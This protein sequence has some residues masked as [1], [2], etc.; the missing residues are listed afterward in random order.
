MVSFNSAKYSLGDTLRVET[1]KD[2]YEGTFLPSED[3]TLITLKLESGY[4]VGVKIKNIKKTDIVEKAKPKKVAPN[5]AVKQDTSLPKITILHTGG[6]IAS[7]VDYSTGGVTA[8]FSPEELL[9]LFPELLDVAQIDSKLVKQMMSENMRFDHYNLLTKAVQAEVKKGVDGIIITHGTDT[10]HYSAASLAFSLVN[11]PIPVIIVGAQRSSDRGSSDAA[12]NLIAAATF[13][14]E[15]D[16]SEVAVCMHQSMNDDACY[17]LPATKVRKMHTSRRD[18][19][20]SINTRPFAKVD[21]KSGVIE[22]INKAYVKRGDKKDLEVKLFKPE[23]KVGL[24]KSHTHMYEEEFLA[25]KDFDGLVIEGTALGQ[26][27]NAKV[28]EFTSESDKI[29]RAIR[30]LTSKMPVV[31]A[32]QCLYGLVDMNVYSEGRRNIDLGVLGN[33]STMTPETTFI[34]LAW[35]LS[36]FDKEAIPELITTNFRGE[37]AERIE[38]DMFLN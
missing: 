24:L 34:K 30:T 16:F 23:L 9:G 7:K 2:V 6:T 32:S 25:F 22:F 14:A 35:L 18:A 21:P 10:L 3:A 37:M 26:L 17:I 1:T 8:D 11:I 38:D 31:M 19:F 29:G 28:D 15:T 4:N 33:Y 36:N 5:K 13:I 20:R 12:F 27:P